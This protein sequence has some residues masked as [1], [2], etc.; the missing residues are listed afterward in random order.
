M[1]Q[2]LVEKNSNVP[3][4][5]I[6]G[7]DAKD[8]LQLEAGNVY[9]GILHEGIVDGT[10][11]YSSNSDN[12]TAVETDESTLYYDRNKHGIWNGVLGIQ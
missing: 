9:N 11:V 7:E 4:E 2:Q 5:E 8:R 6:D 10:Y 1:F 3:D 12:V